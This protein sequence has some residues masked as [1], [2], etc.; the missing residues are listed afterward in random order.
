MSDRAAKP[1][2]SRWWP[3]VLYALVFLA[4]VGAVTFV[5]RGGSTASESTTATDQQA[6]TPSAA[7]RLT[8]SL[9][10]TPWPS[11]T[12]SA[13]QTSAVAGEFAAR[14][15]AETLSSANVLAAGS[16][17][18][19]WL[20][21]EHYK[22]S[23]VVDYYS[24]YGAT[25]M[26]KWTKPTVLV[27]AGTAALED[28]TTDMLETLL[29]NGAMRFL[30]VLTINGGKVVH[31]EVYGDEYSGGAAQPRPF[32][33]PPG[34]ADTSAAAKA[35][36]AAYYAALPKG[37]AGVLA[38]LYSPRV[39]FEDTT[40]SGKAGGRDQAVVWQN[41][42]AAVQGV[43]LQVR[44]LVAGEGWVVARWILSGKTAG[45]LWRSEPGATVFEV[46]G[47]K[48]VRQTLYY[49]HGDSPFSTE[50]TT[51]GPS[52]LATPTTTAQVAAAYAEDS[53]EGRPTIGLF[54]KDAV[55]RDRGHGDLR[56]GVKAIARFQDFWSGVLITFE[57]RS[58]L[59]GSG[60]FVA[61]NTAA[62]FEYGVDVLRVRGGKIVADYLYFDDLQQEPA[63]WD[64]MPLKTPPA[65]SDTEAASG[66]VAKAYMAAMRALSPGRL[67][68]LYAPKVVYQDTGRDVRY[69]GPSAAARAH[70]KMFALKGVRFRANGGLDGP[71]WAAVMWKRSDREGGKPLVDI[72]AV[73]TTWGKRAT[74]HGVS[75]LEIR[76]G[77][78]ARETIYCDHI[79]TRY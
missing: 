60:G 59:V 46:R 61:E 76:D 39:V 28:T 33:T 31:Q 11:G 15:H 25:T 43:S 79:R 34:P 72:P 18:D 14:L 2:Y 10:Y 74:I 68:A 3:L 42:L 47:G 21:D 37:N 73:L 7:P 12:A 5:F 20:A 50:T 70:A 8:P 54:A 23:Y 41:R 36:V 55:L 45:G 38:A 22:G 26:L 69:V 29:G 44:S 77:K 1:F 53:R 65:A 57:P 78:I 62:G 27:T 71:G 35:T 24:P 19:I 64:P 67:A 75:I 58:L 30:D 4:A 40:E 56:V 13:A 16:T 6:L 66:A 63:M 48:I 49:S 32:P 52:P 17:M 9:A 51:S